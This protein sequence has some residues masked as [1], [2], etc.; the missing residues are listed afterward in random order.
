MISKTENFPLFNKPTKRIQQCHEL[1]SKRRKPADNTMTNNASDDNYYL[2]MMWL[3]MGVWSIRMECVV[4]R[5]G[6][7]VHSEWTC[8]SDWNSKDNQVTTI[9]KSFIGITISTLLAYKQLSLL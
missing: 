5:F 1:A 4:C 9:I 7:Y 3:K 6:I 8:M 2:Q